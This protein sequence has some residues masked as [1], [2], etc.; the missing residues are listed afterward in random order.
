[1][2]FNNQSA[3]LKSKIDTV[4]ARRKERNS[5]AINGDDSDDNEDDDNSSSDGGKKPLSI[6]DSRNLKGLQKIKDL[7]LKQNRYKLPKVLTSTP[8]ATK[9]LPKVLPPVQFKHKK[10]PSMKNIN[11]RDAKGSTLGEFEFEIQG[12][13]GAFDSKHTRNL[14][15]TI[16]R[17]QELQKS[18]M[19]KSRTNKLQ[20][21]KDRNSVKTK[22][23]NLKAPYHFGNLKNNNRNNRF[24]GR[25]IKIRYIRR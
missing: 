7:R 4:N 23:N 6:T 10:K 11:L 12:I 19:K 20:L 3:M 2:K 5:S 9:G 21:L 8:S 1:M 18:L 14:F 24:G 16:L 22:T 13:Q 25:T 15:P 17:N